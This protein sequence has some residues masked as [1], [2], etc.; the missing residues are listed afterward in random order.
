MPES[1]LATKSELAAGWQRLDDKLDASVKRLDDKIDDAVKRLSGEIFKTNG[2][3]DAMEGRLSARMD[4]GFDRITGTIDSFAAK[5]ETFARES[6]TLPKT[7]DAHG[8]R[9]KDHEE[10]IG[11]LEAGPRASL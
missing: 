1:E 4:A 5:L 8:L 9:L 3:M 10:R 6:L 11:L 7:L 2:R